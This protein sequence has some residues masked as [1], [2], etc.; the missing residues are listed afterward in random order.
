MKK[1]LID[2]RAR[3]LGTLK[4]V[5]HFPPERTDIHMKY[6]FKLEY[7]QLNKMFQD[8]KRVSAGVAVYRCESNS[9]LPP[10]GEKAV[11]LLAARASM[12][13]LCIPKCKGIPMAEQN[14]HPCSGLCIKWHLQLHNSAAS[15]LQI[16]D[17]AESHH[18]TSGT[19]PGRCIF[20]RDFI[21]SI[22]LLDARF[23]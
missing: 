20:R 15:T 21:L 1:R 2:S 18:F 8:C 14:N 10:E 12:R 4:M 9:V 23:Y 11:M 22:S 6:L 13:A 16:Q 5:F 3:A 17:F 7:L 19:P